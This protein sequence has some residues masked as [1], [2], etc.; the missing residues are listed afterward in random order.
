MNLHKAAFL[1]VLELFGF[2]GNPGSF[3]RM[4]RSLHIPW[5]FILSAELDMTKDRI[6]DI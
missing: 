1:D 3:R 6:A 2:M 5:L 4:G